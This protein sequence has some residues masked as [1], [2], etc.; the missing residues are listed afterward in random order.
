[1]HKKEID[2][3]ESQAKQYESKARD[4]MRRALELRYSDALEAVGWAHGQ[5]VEGL[6]GTRHAGE[7][8]KL[9]GLDYSVLAGKKIKKDGE[10]SMM[11]G[12]IYTPRDWSVVN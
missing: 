9:G 1:M 5:I 2:D 10:L 6:P 7:R 12:R 4:L 3:L 11:S 8:I